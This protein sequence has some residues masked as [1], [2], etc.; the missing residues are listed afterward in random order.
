MKGGIIG[1]AQLANSLIIYVLFFCV[2]WQK[3]SPPVIKTRMHVFL[4]LN[5]VV[6]DRVSVDGAS[7]SRNNTNHT[8]CGLTAAA[9]VRFQPG[10]LA[11]C[12]PLSLSLSVSPC[13]SCLSQTV[14]SIHKAQMPTNIEIPSV[15]G[16]MLIVCLSSLTADAHKHELPLTITS[17]QTTTVSISSN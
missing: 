14:T 16:E 3:Y 8:G 1:L 7:P 4:R 12:H 15:G 6:F 9:R 10:S 5:A 2:S 13:L 17:S 11:A